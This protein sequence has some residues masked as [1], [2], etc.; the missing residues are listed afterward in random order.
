M[1][2]EA[3]F[4]KEILIS[5]TDN[6]KEA[7][8]N[9]L[10]E[11]DAFYFKYL[12]RM[13]TLEQEWKD[14][15]NDGNFDNAY[16][17]PEKL[18]IKSPLTIIDAPWGTGKTHFI[19]TLAKFF[20][21]STINTQRF[22]NIVIIDAWKHIN[23]NNVPDDIARELANVL[24]RFLD[25]DEK[26]EI[27]KS[28][29][30]EKWINWIKN[31]G[32]K[33][34]AILLHCFG[35][36]IPIEIFNSKKNYSEDQNSNQNKQEYQKLLEKIDSKLKPTLVIFDNIERMGYHAI[37]IIKTI[38]QLSIF[39]KFIFVIPMNKNQ[40]TLGHKNDLL[41]GETAIDKYISLGTFFVLKWN[42]IGLLKSFRC[43]YYY[44]IIIDSILKTPI[45]NQK[46]LSIR[47]LE[48]CLNKFPIIETFC[49]KGTS[50][51]LK[52]LAKIWNPKSKIQSIIDR[53][54]LK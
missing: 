35:I 45:A 52:V 18:S 4:A 29:Q 16:F 26:S 5:Q 44:C 33:S 50:E 37:E 19:E 54:E 46:Q 32:L 7:C 51:G 23:S 17:Y 36:P 2:S 10:V 41:L 39:K 3:L 43:P 28:E 53:E 12:S 21:K 34:V 1:E 47:T 11:L 42:Y 25:D 24:D 15:F 40:L 13:K 38:Q 31:N 8:E 20:V 9:F 22:K 27:K 48:I 6:L 14:K 30:F 49:R